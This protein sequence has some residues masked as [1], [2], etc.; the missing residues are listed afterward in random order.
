MEHQQVWGLATGVHGLGCFPLRGGCQANTSG[1][2]C[3]GASPL[4]I[5]SPEA[6][7]SA[8]EPP[9]LPPPPLLTASE[10]VFARSGGSALV[11]PHLSTELLRPLPGCMPWHSRKWTCTGRQ[12]ACVPVLL[13][14][15][16]MLLEEDRRICYLEAGSIR[17][18]PAMLHMPPGPRLMP[19]ASFALQ[20][21]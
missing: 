9:L 10:A 2:G 17:I 7:P 12:C 11:L 4:L 21:A 16:S 15:Q 5:T 20:V 13:P 14:V 6:R 19:C 8:A 18:V 3:C 1:G